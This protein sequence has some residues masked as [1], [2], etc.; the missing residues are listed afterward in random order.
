MSL[1]NSNKIIITYND[2]LYFERCVNNYIEVLKSFLM[3]F[4]IPTGL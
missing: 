2:Y 1:K 3:I 4:R